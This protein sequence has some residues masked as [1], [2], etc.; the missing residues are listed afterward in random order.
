M[1][2]HALSQNHPWGIPKEPS[3]SGLSQNPDK[4]YLGL[5][6]TRALVQKVTG[7]R[8]CVKRITQ[9]ETPALLAETAGDLLLPAKKRVR[10]E[11]LAYRNSHRL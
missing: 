3:R 1:Q 8:Y 9:T 2:R 10:D 11:C 5:L 4:P 6:E 7:K